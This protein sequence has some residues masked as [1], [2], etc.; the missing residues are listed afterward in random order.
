MESLC[1]CTPTR[2]A[3]IEARPRRPPVGSRGWLRF[4]LGLAVG[5]LVVTAACVFT[6]VQVR[7][8]LRYTAK[9]SPW[10]LAGCVASALVDAALQSLRWRAVMRPVVALRFRQAYAAR[11]LA[12]M[13]NAFLP[14]RGGDLIRVQWL[15]RR[16]G[17]SRTLLLATEVVDRWLDGWGWMPLLLV[18]GLV[19]HPPAWLSR[20]LGTFGGLLL[21]S[22]AAMWL[23]GRRASPGAK[24]NGRLS[25][26]W[27]ALRAGVAAFRSART[28]RIALLL[29]PLPWLWESLAIFWA[30]RAFGIEMPWP[31]A[32]SVLVAFNLA[33][34]VPSPGSI[35][36]VEAGGTAALV[37][38][39]VDQSQAL[40]FMCV[41]HFTQL[42]PGVLAGALVVLA[43]KGR[44]L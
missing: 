44:V 40:A 34:L 10:L 11:M 41:Y 12:F 32:F 17:R 21:V 30:T 22:G 23:L 39:G 3:D 5:T 8:V 28:W 33:T 2:A 25:H 7:E 16:S 29:A 37:L 1:L 19:S 9:V 14:G 4:A 38:C 43:Q 26:L 18:V 24:E 31:A 20:A 36:A 6:G 27:S 35:G 15:G 42:L 13:F